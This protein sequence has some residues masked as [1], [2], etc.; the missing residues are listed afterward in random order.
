[1][2]NLDFPLPPTPCEAIMSTEFIQLT[3]GEF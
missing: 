1:M 2:N 3:A